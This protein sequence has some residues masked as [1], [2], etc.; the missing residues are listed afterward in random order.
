MPILLADAN[1]NG[2]IK[3]LVHRDAELEPWV[4]FWTDLQMS[5]VF[6]ADVGLDQADT[7]AV[8]WRVP[9]MES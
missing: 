8:V 3:R 6:F 2:H 9:V 4:E 7:D 5:C 1:I